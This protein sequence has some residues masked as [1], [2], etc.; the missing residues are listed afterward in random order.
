MKKTKWQ[1]KK[2]TPFYRKCIA[3]CKTFHICA[4]ICFW[5]WCTHSFF[6]CDKSCFRC[7]FSLR[8]FWVVTKMFVPMRNEG[9][10]VTFLS[11]FGHFQPPSECVDWSAVFV[12]CLFLAI[13]LQSK[14][15]SCGTIKNSVEVTNN[16]LC[17]VFLFRS[18]DF[19]YKHLVCLET[20][21][22]KL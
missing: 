12:G 21:I 10:S 5:L 15:F 22:P 9:P 4:G 16:V 1:G 14:V 18:L 17:N 20:K 13:G 2:M 8:I 6:H 11:S 3:I 7:C 19:H